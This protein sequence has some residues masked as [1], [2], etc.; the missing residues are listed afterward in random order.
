VK[1]TL[2][3]LALLVTFVFGVAGCGSD[4]ITPAESRIKNSTGDPALVGSMIDPKDLLPKADKELPDIGVL[5]PI[6][7]PSL[8]NANQQLRSDPPIP[9][10]QT[11]PWNQSPIVPDLLRR[12]FDL[13]SD[14]IDPIDKSEMTEYSEFMRMFNDS[15]E[16]II[17]YEPD[18][19]S[20][21]FE[22]Y[23]KID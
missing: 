10:V 9:Q 17:Q 7:E 16:D 8:R 3:A 13:G 11:G 23:I 22:P 4:E 6:Q 15:S 5:R 2:L 18:G 19:V 12:P 21:I 1:R 20:G 14:D